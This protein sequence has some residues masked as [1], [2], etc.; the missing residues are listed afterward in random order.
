MENKPQSNNSK[1]VLAW[2]LI[3]IGILWILR[4]ID[5]YFDIPHFYFQNIF[6]PFKN[7]FHDL[8]HFIFSWQMVLIIV[9]LILM[10]GK[11]SSGIVLIVIGGIF[12]LPK[13]L[14]VPGITFS[15]FFPVL[16]VGLGIAM[17]VKRI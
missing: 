1:V 3:G 12:L 10:A 17:I 8:T 7:I 5:F 14:I 16:L 2:V 13:F 4:K 9:G 6:F 11:R 15:M